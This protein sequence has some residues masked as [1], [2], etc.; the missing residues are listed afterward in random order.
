MS[1]PPGVAAGRFAGRYTVEREIGRGATAVVYLARDATRG[2]AVA[3][4][5]LRPELAQSGAAQS[6]LREIRRH[7]E[8][9]HPRI[10]PVLDAG[11][12]EG[13]LYFV[14]P[15]MEGGTLRQRLAREKQ[16]PVADAVAIARTIAEAHGG[17][18]DVASVPGAGATFTLR[19]PV[20]PPSQ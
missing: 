6:F 18:I 15:Y 1:S 7:S 20:R 10:L 3:I 17:S 12:Q 9:Q 13:Q 14:L 8:L 11:Q 5:V 19:L 4:K 2:R 16:L